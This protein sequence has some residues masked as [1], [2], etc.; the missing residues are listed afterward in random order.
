MIYRDGG[1][2]IVTQN[3]TKTFDEKGVLKSVVCKIVV[4]ATVL[5][6]NNEKTITTHNY[7]VPLPCPTTHIELGSIVGPFKDYL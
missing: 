7:S 2:V 1:D 5:E 6:T 3:E 4:E